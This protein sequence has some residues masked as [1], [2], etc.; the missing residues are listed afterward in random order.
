NWDHTV[1][2]AGILYKG[3]TMC[4]RLGICAAVV[5]ALGWIGAALS[6]EAPAD[7]TTGAEIAA[8]YVVSDVGGRIG[9]VFSADG[10]LLAASDPTKSC[11]WNLN[12]GMKLAEVPDRRLIA[13]SPDF[14]LFVC[15]QDNVATVMNM[16]ATPPAPISAAGGPAARAAFSKDGKLCAFVNFD[17]NV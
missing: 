5:V 8:K 3:A 13:C 15:W 12:T 11:V 17:G 9:V 14:N 1:R 2:P 6:A 10:A 4:S 16:K 7:D